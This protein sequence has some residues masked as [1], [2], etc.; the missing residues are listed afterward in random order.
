VRD[1][2]R[3]LGI[4]TGAIGSQLASP[5]LGCVSSYRHDGVTKAGAGCPRNRG[6][7][8]MELLLVRADYRFSSAVK[9]SGATWL[10]DSRDE[11]LA[12][13]VRLV[14]RV[15]DVRIRCGQLKKPLLDTDL[16]ATYSLGF[17]V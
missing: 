7:N 17:V 2:H 1:A 12:G 16:C 5:R 14:D 4:K 11:E 15:Q 13:A 6:N 10:R 9:S 8:S 3:S